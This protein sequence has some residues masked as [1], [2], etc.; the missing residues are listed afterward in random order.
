MIQFIK[1]VI[2]FIKDIISFM[3]VIWILP[4]AAWNMFSIVFFLEK[5]KAKISIKILYGLLLFIISA[6]SFQVGY[7]FLGKALYYTDHNISWFYMFITYIFINIP[8]NIPDIVLKTFKKYKK[9][10]ETT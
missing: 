10:S 5:M 7:I 8:M 3:L 2:S 9:G 6:V 4:L 1:D